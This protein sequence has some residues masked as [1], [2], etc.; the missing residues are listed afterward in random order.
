M[1]DL[2]INI[3]TI[4]L[5]IIFLSDH[6]RIITLETG[7]SYN[8]KRMEKMEHSFDSVVATVVSYAPDPQDGDHD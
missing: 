5:C 8:A 7:A 6:Y 4:V 1:K 3:T 2:R